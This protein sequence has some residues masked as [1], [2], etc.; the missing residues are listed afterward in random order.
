VVTVRRLLRSLVNEL[1][2][3]FNL[4]RFLAGYS[5]DWVPVW[6][7]GL[8][9]CLPFVSQS[10]VS[11]A[12][13]QTLD[14]RLNLPKNDGMEP[15]DHR[16]LPRKAPDKKRPNNLVLRLS[17]AELARLVD[18]AAKAGLSRSDFI[19]RLLSRAR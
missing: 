1:V 18:L 11:S 15:I 10:Q 3:W 14:Q 16:K 19:R 8:W 12:M 9:S 5:R 13:P 2:W 6:L 17:D 4:S 7:A